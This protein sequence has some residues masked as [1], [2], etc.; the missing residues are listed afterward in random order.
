M[1]DKNCCYLI[2]EQ[3]GILIKEMIIK[4]DLLTVG[5]SEH[6]SMKL[7]RQAKEFMVQRG[8]PF[9]KNKR[10]GRV[11]KEIVESILGCELELE[12][13]IHGKN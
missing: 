8:Y 9:Y 1:I 3:G 2:E 11:P 7:I 12:E 6:T 5:F 13:N 10:L 4:K